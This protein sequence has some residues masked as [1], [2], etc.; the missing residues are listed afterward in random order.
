MVFDQLYQLR[1]DSGAFLIYDSKS[2]AHRKNDAE[3]WWRT[4]FFKEFADGN[5]IAFQTSERRNFTLKFVQRKLTDV[6]QKAL[7]CSHTFRCSVKN[8]GLYWDSADRIPHVNQQNDAA[9]DPEGWL[10]IKKGEYSVTVSALDWFQDITEAEREAAGSIAHFVVQFEKA[11]KQDIE[12]PAKLP[13]L[14]PSKKYLDQRTRENPSILNLYAKHAFMSVDK[15]LRFAS[16]LESP[17]KKTNATKKKNADAE[18][19]SY[20]T[21]K[22]TLELGGKKFKGYEIGSYA[23]PDGSWLWSWENK[24]RDLVKENRELKDRVRKIGETYG[25][26]SFSFEHFFNLDPLLGS[27]LQP[28]AVNVFGAII[29]GEL[30]FDAY[31]KPTFANGDTLVV[32]SDKNIVAPDVD[33]VVRLLEVIPLAIEKRPIPNHKL[34]VIVYAKAYGL[35]PTESNGKLQINSDDGNSLEAT[36]DEY[37]R[38]TDLKAVL[39]AKV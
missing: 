4:D 32:V 10:A 19:W 30:N 33:P 9:D 8:K 1:A 22:A 34:A 14:P 29:C 13:W 11:S 25:I 24:T 2:L 35:K 38:I 21:S 39:P 26:S 7:V 17:S 15:Q 31:Y 20:T 23:E 16:Y 6:E 28:H 18:S 27:D 3:D 36:F 5:L 37:N 12:I